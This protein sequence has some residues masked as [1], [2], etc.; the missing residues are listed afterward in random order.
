M[1]LPRFLLPFVPP[2]KNQ[3][4]TKTLHPL[5]DERNSSAVPPQF[6][7]GSGTLFQTIIRNSL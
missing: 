2:N 3:L 5:E 6:A 1:L 7:K 4:K